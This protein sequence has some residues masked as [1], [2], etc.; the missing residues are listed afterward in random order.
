MPNK[1][2]F[3][4]NFVYLFV[5]ISL[6]PFLL[7]A[8]GGDRNDS[9]DAEEAQSAPVTDS[10]SQTAA[11]TEQNQSST[12]TQETGTGAQSADSTTTQQPATQTS[13][14]GITGSGTPPSLPAPLYCCHR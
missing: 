13:Q 9:T 7:V 6:F 10:S 3:T 11:T 4:S 1:S 5:I 14:T 12:Q 8:C 2:R